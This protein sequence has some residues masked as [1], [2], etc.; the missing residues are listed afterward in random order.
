MKVHELIITF[1]TNEEICKD[2]VTSI[3][4]NALETIETQSIDVPALRKSINKD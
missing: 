1:K 2:L 3:V 4:D